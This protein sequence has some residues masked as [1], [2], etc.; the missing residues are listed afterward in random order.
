MHRGKKV[1]TRGGHFRARK[2]AGRGLR[3]EAGAGNGI[4]PRRAPQG[5]KKGDTMRFKS[6]LAAS[7]LLMAFA[8]VLATP[9]LAQY[10]AGSPAITPV[11][12]NCHKNQNL[13]TML[14]AHGAK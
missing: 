9:A 1:G 13:S 2:E 14:T 10:V 12:A 5:N 11:G 7:G 4:S 8:A 3:R 6:I